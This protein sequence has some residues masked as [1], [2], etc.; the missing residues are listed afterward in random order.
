MQNDQ[1]KKNLSIK[2][3]LLNGNITKNSKF[4]YKTEYFF[5]HAV[6]LST[7]GYI[8]AGNGVNNGTNGDNLRLIKLDENGYVYPYFIKGNI[9][10]DRDNDCKISGN[11]LPISRV[12][13]QAK[14]QSNQDFYALSDSLG[15][16]DLNVD[17]G[18]YNVSV[19]PPSKY[20]TACTPSVLK[21]FRSQ[22]R[23]IRPISL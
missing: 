12:L 7:G 5:S 3:Y 23:Q 8:V 2:Q 15:N 1:Y 4:N 18:T 11:D 6:T 13:V 10:S 16:Y 9:A 21:I 20:M 19:V 17:L 22:I 14:N